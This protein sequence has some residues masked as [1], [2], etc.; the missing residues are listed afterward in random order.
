MYNYLRVAYYLESL[1]RHTRWSQGQLEDYQNRRLREVVGYAYENVEFYHQKLR[2]FGVKPA[3]VRT[4]DDLKKLPMVERDELQKN[5]ER[6]VSKRFSLAS[7]RVSS[8]S[9]SSGRPLFTYLTKAEDEFRKAKLLRPHV[10]CGQK[11]WDKWVLIEPLQNIRGAGRLQRLV[12]FYT[13]V[14]VSIF[15]AP[16]RQV[17]MIEKLRPDVLDGLSNSLFLVAQEIEERGLVTIRPR[18]VM[19]GAEQLVASDRKIIERS[20]DAPFYDQYASEEVQMIAWQCTEKDEYHIDADSLVVEFVDEAGEEVAPG[21]KGELVC[22]SLFNRAM[23]FLRYRLG[24]LAVRSEKTDCACGR[25][26]PLLKTIE[27]RKDSFVILPNGRKVPPLA[28]GYAMEFYRF[29]HDVYQYRIIQK[30]SNVLMFE[31]RK[32]NGAAS[33]AEMRM[34]LIVHMRRMLGINE[35]EV[36]VDVE[37]VDSIPLDKSGKLR[38]VISEM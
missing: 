21:E 34:E 27:G 26:F 8:T 11:P 18:F 20:L 15:D 16:S 14:Y 23:P 37:F 17:S 24:D 29:Y 19:G 25:S 3:D 2:Q 1:L 22:T 12:R 5:S 32:K 31:V 4:I 9:G 7:L 10:I 38:K 35:S 36:V 28:F 30:K 6:L 13:P 33:E